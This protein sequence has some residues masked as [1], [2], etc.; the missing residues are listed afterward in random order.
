VL[1]RLFFAFPG[2]W[3]GLALLL[4]RAVLGMAILTQGSFY[5][6]EPNP[7]TATWFMGL[8]AFASGALLLAG[9]ATPI[10]GALVAVAAAAVGLSLLPGCVPTLFDSKISLIFGLTML[11][12]IIGLGPGAFSLDARMFGRREIIIPPRASQSQE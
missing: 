5:I 11:V 3:P 12:T 7:T 8:S 10:I 4:L 1:R 6:G 2:G 9:F